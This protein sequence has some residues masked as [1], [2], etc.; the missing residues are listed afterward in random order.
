ML[1]FENNVGPI[2][3]SGNSS[4]IAKRKHDEGADGHASKVLVGKIHF[5]D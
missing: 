1:H 5:T 3:C 4:T 2:D